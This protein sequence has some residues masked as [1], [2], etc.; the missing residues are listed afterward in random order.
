MARLTSLAM[1]GFSLALRHQ[2]CSSPLQRRGID[3]QT[4]GKPPRLKTRVTA[5]TRIKKDLNRATSDLE[6]RASYLLD[7]ARFTHHAI[8]FQHKF[9]GDRLRAEPFHVFANILLHRDCRLP[10]ES[11][12][13]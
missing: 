8:R 11:T 12:H 7:Y 3:C 13:P 2:G 10:S 4:L 9:L 1:P 5:T 6:T